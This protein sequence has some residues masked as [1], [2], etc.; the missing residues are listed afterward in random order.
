MKKKNEIINEENNKQLMVVEDTEKLGFV[1]LFWVFFITCFLGV[2]VELIWCIVRFHKIESRS[3]LVYGPFNL[4]YG[5]GALFVTMALYR[6]AKKNVKFGKIKI[7]F[8]GAMIGSA[9]EYVCSFFQEVTFG[10][11]SWDYSAGP[12]S[13]NGRINLL[14][15]IF[16]GFLSL[17]WICFLLPIMLQWI[18]KIPKK[19]EYGLTISLLIFMIFNSAISFCAANRQTERYRNIPAKNKWDTFLDTHFPDERLDKIY[20]NKMHK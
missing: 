14:Y 9:F 5:F 13:L 20:A 7:F 19:L 4:V 12:F 17:G 3:G 15:A 11:I 8:W 6:F 18:K 16:W 10:T 2:V 1:Q